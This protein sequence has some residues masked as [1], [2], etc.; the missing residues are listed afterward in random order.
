MRRESFASI[1]YGV[2]VIALLGG[3]YIAGRATSNRSLASAQA[4]AAAGPLAVPH[5]SSFLCTVNN[6]AAFDNRVHVRC[7][8]SPGGGG[9]YCFGYPSDPAHFSTANQILA[10]ANT[11]FALGRPAWVYYHSSSSMNPTG[12]NTGDCRGLFGVSMVE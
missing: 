9:I 2:P 7:T 3:A 5:A 1:V 10:V 11:A 12:C 4:G 6:V 8:S